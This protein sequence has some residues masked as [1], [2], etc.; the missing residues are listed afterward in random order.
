M[1]LH[2][3]W[4][5]ALFLFAAIPLVFELTYIGIMFGML[6]NIDSQKQT[7]TNSMNASYAVSRFMVRLLDSGATVVG[8][9]LGMMNG[10]GR[11]LDPESFDRYKRDY[12]R[13]RMAIEN[14]LHELV[15]FLAS[16]AK[17]RSFADGLD[18]QYFALDTA[19]KAGTRLFREGD[20]LAAL[21][22]RLRVISHMENMIAMSRQF[23]D[24]QLT[25]TF[26]LEQ[27]EERMKAIM[28]V[29]IVAF[30]FSSFIGAGLLA[31]LVNRTIVRKLDCLSESVSKL[32]AH[33]PIG[34]PMKGNDEFS[35][36]DGAFRNMFD[37]IGQAQSKERLVVDSALDM[38]CTLSETGVFTRVNPACHRILGRRPEEM[39]GCGIQQ[40]VVDE[41]RQL[42]LHNLK[43]S[44]GS[45]NTGN[46]EMALLDG[47]GGQVDTLWSVTWSHAEQSFF[48]VVHDITERKQ[49]E[50]LR[51]EITAMISHDLRTPI[52]SIQVAL[53]LLNAGAFGVL[54]QQFTNETKAA[55][56]QSLEA[57]DLINDLLDIEKF[58]RAEVE[59]YMRPY[60]LTDLIDS[61]WRDIRPGAAL[62]G[63][64]IE[65]NVR[66][67]NLSV[68]RDQFVR[69]LRNLL[70][71]SVANTPEAST[72]FVSGTQSDGSF[73]LAIE[74]SG[75]LVAEEQR[76]S[77]FDRFQEIG[78][79]VSSRT[80]G[81]GLSL[82]VCK[83]L[84]LAHGGTLSAGVSPSNRFEFLIQIPAAS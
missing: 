65:V 17:Y 62:K 66:S 73:V 41:E 33:E 34:P 76:E 42:A 21:K 60:L 56:M 26:E 46:F 16:E 52:T 7:R 2:L 48:C 20:V 82:A 68:D 12:W 15:N 80:G 59:L 64:E 36:L 49:S 79:N 4:S 13:G 70:R 63:I 39:I 5:H 50:L 75:P 1:K 57:M 51:Q 22:L 72:I 31:F 55:G 44:A 11:G 45:K 32:A 84:V 8:T 77:I 27:R 19:L 83:A 9:E 43:V 40:F 6:S 38:I 37:A 18:K 14:S 47:L 3:N 10:G 58:E 74:D 28:Q 81:A 71:N 69:I 54:P 25:S 35:K 24:R 53:E 30:F 23:V 78:K 29:V 67:L 61:A